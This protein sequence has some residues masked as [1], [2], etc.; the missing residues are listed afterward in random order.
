MIV[1]VVKES[2]PGERRVA[3]VP[4]AVPVLVKAGFEVVI[5]SGAGVPAGFPDAAY[6]E[7]GARLL[8]DRPD[9]FAE[10]GCLLHVRMLG[11]NLEL[12]LTDLGYLR[13]GQALIG[14]CDPLASAGAVSVRYRHRHARCRRRLNVLLRGYRA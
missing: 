6:R 8:A 2:L 1:G 4:G 14:F 7:R 13:A 3:L 5:E 11:A 9:V 12:G 10:A